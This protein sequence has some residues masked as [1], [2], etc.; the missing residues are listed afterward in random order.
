VTHRAY[1]KATT[2]VGVSITGHVARIFGCDCLKLIEIR[3]WLLR[4]RF[5]PDGGGQ[6][7]RADINLMWRHRFVHLR[8]EAS[9]IQ[10]IPQ[11]RRHNLPVAKCLPGSITCTDKLHN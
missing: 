10:S 6:V 7:I 5:T 9:I 8:C 4:K 1:V 11:S 3:G 2:L